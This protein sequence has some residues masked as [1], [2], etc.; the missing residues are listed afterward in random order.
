MSDSLKFADPTERR[1]V[2]RGEITSTVRDGHGL[3]IGGGDQLRLTD[4]AGHPFAIARVID[5]SETRLYNA[6]TV[7]HSRGATHLA[8]RQ[9]QLEGILSKYYD[10]LDR[11]SPVTVVVFEVTEVLEPGTNAMNGHHIEF[12]RVSCPHCDGNL[13]R[14]IKREGD[15]V[16]VYEFAPGDSVSELHDRL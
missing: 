16:N 4:D 15:D 6:M 10:H 12:K 8:D 7:I 14:A 5:V 1:Q 11:Q 13:Y 9:S 3:G 2:R